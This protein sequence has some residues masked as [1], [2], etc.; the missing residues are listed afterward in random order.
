MNVVKANPLQNKVHPLTAA[1]AMAFGKMLNMFQQV[2]KTIPPT[3]SKWIAKNLKKL[4]PVIDRHNL[5]KQALYDQFVEQHNGKNVVWD[6]MPEA[7]KGVYDE[8]IQ[9]VRRLDNNQPIPNHLTQNYQFSV[10]PEK[11]E[12][13]DLKM[14][15]LFDQKEEVHICQMEQGMLGNVNIPGNVDM[16]ILYDVLTFDENQETDGNQN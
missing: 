11:K 14:K 8:T 3:P 4:K 15:E 9:A 6:Y 7:P 13:Y 12:E 1:E 16:V 2:N 5:Q 10:A